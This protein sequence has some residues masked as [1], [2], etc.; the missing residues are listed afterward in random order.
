MLR[1]PK[2]CG[3]ML[4]AGGAL[5]LFV[6]VFLAWLGAQFRP[7]SLALAAVSAL[8]LGVLALKRPD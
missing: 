3:V 1:Q 2:R 8:V 6:S 5:A 7:E 4:V